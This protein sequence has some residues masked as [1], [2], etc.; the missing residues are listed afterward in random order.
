MALCWI[1][2]PATEENLDVISMKSQTIL[3][4]KG[5]FFTFVESWPII[6]DVYANLL[7]TEFV[8][9]A[10]RNKVIKNFYFMQD[11][12]ELLLT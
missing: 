2:I 4:S 5:V 9:W 11:K 10:R 3:S 12:M 8:F 1:R 7:K 6:G